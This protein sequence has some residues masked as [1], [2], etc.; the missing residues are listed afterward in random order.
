MLGIVH[1]AD[2]RDQAIDDCTY[3]LQDFANYFGAAGFVPLANAVDGHASRRANSSRSMRARAIAAS[4]HPGDAIAY[5]QDLLDRSGGFGT[6]LLLGHDWAS[7]RATYH[8]YELFAREVIP[9]FKGQ[10][11]APRCVAR[12]GQGHARPTARPRRRG[13][14]QGD[15]RTHRRTQDGRGQELMRASVLRDGCMVLRD[16]VAEPEP[17]PGQVLVGVRACGIC[18]S[19]LHFAKHGADVLA[20]SA[21]RCRATPH[22][23]MK[24]DLN[25]DIFMGH[26]FS[27]EVL[28]A[29]PDTDAPT[30]GN[31]RHVDTGAAVVHRYRPDRLLQHHDWRLRASGCCCRH[32]CC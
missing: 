4:A 14:R 7:P 26:E 16:D 27:A 24:I 2:T 9:Y 22:G 13:H 19:D 5:I 32:R 11:T 15:L 20:N 28:E 18:G 1:L 3:G 10:L 23:G 6:F 29:G 30:A 21:G 12:L 17:G 25:R 31:A 8:S